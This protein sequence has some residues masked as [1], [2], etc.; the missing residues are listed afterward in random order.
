MAIIAPTDANDQQVPPAHLPRT[1]TPRL[2]ELLKSLCLAD[3]LQRNKEIEEENASRRK[4]TFNHTRDPAVHPQPG[5]PAASLITL[6]SRDLDDLRDYSIFERFK[7]LLPLDLLKSLA[8]SSKKRDAEELLDPEAFILKRRRCHLGEREASTSSLGRQAPINLDSYT[9][10]VLFTTEDHVA[11]PL[12]FFLTKNLRYI[13]A[14]GATITQN[15]AN[16]TTQSLNA[17]ALRI[18]D[19]SKL[20]A[21]FGDELDMTL[22]EWSEAANNWFQFQSRRDTEGSDGRFTRFI[23]QH[24]DFFQECED[25]IEYY[26]AWKSLEQKLRADY[27]ANPTPFDE[28][29]Y[30]VLYTQCKMM[31]DISQQMSN[32]L[33][34]QF[35]SNVS[36]RRPFSQG[37]SS[38]YQ[39]AQSSRSNSSP[40][41]FPQSSAQLPNSFRPFRQKLPM[42]PT[43]ILCAQQGHGADHHYDDPKPVTFSDSKKTW[44]RIADRRLLTPSGQQLCIPFNVRGADRCHCTHPRDV[45]IHCCSFCGNEN[46]HALSWTCRARPAP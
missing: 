26:P 13:A 43:C 33:P 23:A 18:Y 15:K 17:K 31:H 34:Q 1:H 22:P 21:I 44:A 19:V 24:L 32:K 38:S 20:Q 35:R 14:N 2:I 16:P 45:R 36:S 6:N 3:K 12:N 27:R 30:G 41:F 29:K 4:K 5:S 37:S 40:G 25:R 46:H 10:E 11:L 42:P 8:P 39:A 28:N 7:S 9:F